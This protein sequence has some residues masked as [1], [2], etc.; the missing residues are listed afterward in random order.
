M[1][2]RVSI[3]IP[4][5]NAEKH[6]ERCLESFLRQT[7]TDIEILLIDDGSS[8]KSKLICQKFVQRDERFKYY[9]Q[10]NAGV[11]AARNKGISLAT[12]KYIGFCDSDDWVENDMYEILIS[13]LEEYDADVSIVSC[14]AHKQNENPNYIDSEKTL[15]LTPE[16]AIKEMHMT[17]HYEGQLWNKLFKRELFQKIQ[18]DENIKIFEDLLVL[19]SIFLKSNKIVYKDVHKYHYI[20]NDESALNSVYSA[21]DLDRIKACN[22]MKKMARDNY[23]NLEKYVDRT[24][25]MAC[26]TISK[27]I[28]LSDIKDKKNMKY[29]RNTAKEIYTKELEDILPEDRRRKAVIFLKYYYLFVL[30]NK[31]SFWKKKYLVK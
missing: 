6:I 25:L 15:I 24:L 4:V 17:R 19:W 16:S 20:I 3:I 10:A 30:K 31:I 5:Y 14:I 2:G 13:L 29:L 27:K 1:E 26:I 11:S 9:Y 28:I 18:L 12:G 8:D 23:P 22:K 7:Y 21:K